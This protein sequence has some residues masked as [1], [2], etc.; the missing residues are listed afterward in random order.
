MGNKVA[1]IGIFVKKREVAQ[2]LNNLL[3][4]FG[5]CII[6]RMGIP[7]REKS[8][9]IICI[10]VDAPKN[11][12]EELSEKIEKIDKILLIYPSILF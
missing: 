6:G 1:L 3:T 5:D 2:E 8:V 10:V 7:H 11:V 9:N 12:I 4:E